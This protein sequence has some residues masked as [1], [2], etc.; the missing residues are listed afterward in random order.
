LGVDLLERV[1]H[2]T[3]GMVEREKVATSPGAIEP[4]HTLR[5][6]FAE[7]LPLMGIAI[8]I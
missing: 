2:W 6:P 8:E 4:T 1:T 5:T 7:I 3:Q